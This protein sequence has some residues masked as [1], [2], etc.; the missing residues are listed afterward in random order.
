MKITDFAAHI[1]RIEGG[2]RQID[3]AQVSEVLKIVNKELFGIPYLLIRIK[4]TGR[5]I[6]AFLLI[7]CLS[8]GCLELMRSCATIPPAPVEAAEPDDDCQGNHPPVAVISV[9]GAAA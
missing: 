4:G 1:T 6:A 3:V 8:V 7:A 5:S 9:T 2:K